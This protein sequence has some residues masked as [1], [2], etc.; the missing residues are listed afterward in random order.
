VAGLGAKTGL[1]HRC[2]QV[3]GRAGQ[4][5][6]HSASE[7]H[8]PWQHVLSPLRGYLNPGREIGIQSTDPLPRR[9]NIR[10]SATE[11]AERRPQVLEECVCPGPRPRTSLATLRTGEIL[12]ISQRQE[13]PAPTRIRRLKRSNRAD[14][15][16]RR[17]NLDIRD[18]GTGTKPSGRDSDSPRVVS[19]ISLPSARR[20]NVRANF[21]A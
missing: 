4:V 11:S 1:V 8:R 5:C 18:C 19:A 12:R 20:V 9:T 15:P 3:L 16:C 21:C 10:P 2:G 6:L 7:P 13:W 14:A 17:A